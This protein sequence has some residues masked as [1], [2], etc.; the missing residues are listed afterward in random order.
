MKDGSYP[1]KMVY[2]KIFMSIF[3]YLFFKGGRFIFTQF[4]SPSWQSRNL[5][6][7]MQE[8]ERRKI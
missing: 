7:G 2:L 1:C 5:H 6:P 4:F 3:I 8:A